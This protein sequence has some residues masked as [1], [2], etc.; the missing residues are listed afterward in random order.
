MRQAYGLIAEREL[1]VVH[2]EQR[3]VEQ[4]AEDDITTL[5]CRRPQ[6]PTGET[7]HHRL[8]HDVAG[9]LDARPRSLGGHCPAQPLWLIVERR[10]NVGLGFLQC[11]LQGLDL[12]GVFV[13][14]SS[15]E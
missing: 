3:S 8:F 4:R 2:R 6:E 7:D 13:G 15:G 1:L 5:R 9:E 11:R 14:P 10:G 12:V